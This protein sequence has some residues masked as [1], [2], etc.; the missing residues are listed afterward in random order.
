MSWNS[1]ALNEMSGI[2]EITVISQNDKNIRKIINH[3]DQDHIPDYRS[4]LSEDAFKG[5]NIFEQGFIDWVEAPTRWVLGSET[6][7]RS[8]FK[9]AV[10]IYGER[11]HA[12]KEA[13]D[14]NG[15]SV[16]FI[17]T[18]AITSFSGSHGLN[19]LLD[20]PEMDFAV[21]S[22]EVTH[23][24]DQGLGLFTKGELPDKK[25]FKLSDGEEVPLETLQ[26]EVIADITTAL[27]IASHTRNWDIID[28]TFN[29][30]RFLQQHDVNHATYPW[31][32]ELKQA[33]DIEK[34]PRLNQKSAFDMANTIYRSMDF[35][36]LE[37]QA[38][39]NVFLSKFYEY[40]VTGNKFENRFWIKQPK[41]WSFLGAHAPG[42]ALKAIENYGIEQ[43]R[44]QVNHIAYRSLEGNQ[45]VTESLLDMAHR[46]A[47]GFGDV[48]LKTIVSD[49][50]RAF[51]DKGVIDVQEIANAIGHPIS[52]DI[53]KRYNENAKVITQLSYDFG[54]TVEPPKS[55][56]N[57]FAFRGLPGNATSK[58]SLRERLKDDKYLRDEERSL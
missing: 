19:V 43:I 24:Q 3:L 26:K 47:N 13:P 15:E 40:I 52:A 1:I 39:A 28:Y 48:S 25:R 35:V 51:E 6:S 58:Q 17:Q 5:R 23:C 41:L 20:D 31:L 32:K 50:R 10:G 21:I 14:E 54:L 8:A 55:N 49:Q 9:A 22:H 16:C 11:A 46:H 53:S 37:N 30:F 45:E 33:T 27:L 4:A 36:D 44:N 57:Q 56:R 7:R 38:R 29:P 42:D 18:N 12:I 34:M 2:P